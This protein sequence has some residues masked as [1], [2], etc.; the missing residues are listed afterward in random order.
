[1]TTQKIYGVD[2]EID[3][4]PKMADQ[5]NKAFRD[6]SW[7][8]KTCDE[9]TNHLEN[10][11]IKESKTTLTQP[12]GHNDDREAEAQKLVQKTINN[13]G[14]QITKQNY[15]NFIEFAV[16]II[17]ELKEKRPVNNKCKTREELEEQEAKLKEKR[18]EEC[19]EIQE[20]EQKRAKFSIL[21]RLL[22]IKK[23]RDD[24][25]LMTDYFGEITLE[26]WHIKELP[27]GRDDFKKMREYISLYPGLRD[28]NWEEHRE[29]YSMGKGYYLKAGLKETIPDHSGQNR[30]VWYEV[31]FENVSIT[32]ALDHW[33]EKA[34]E[35][36]LPEVQINHNEKLNGLEVKFAAKPSTEIL[37]QLKASGM[38]WSNRKRLWYARY[39][40]ELETRIKALCC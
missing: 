33:P 7:E 28:L 38:R 39:N 35:Q 31:S 6:I 20:Q 5:V 24:S 27:Q 36:Q 1:M 12:F 16:D 40:Q 4:G 32:T 37:S 22:V 13:L 26:E 10:G 17:H 15:E 19:R 2:V 23:V 14:H 9:L 21:N 25:D 34:E 8:T 18:E 29:K 3:L 30:G 11:E